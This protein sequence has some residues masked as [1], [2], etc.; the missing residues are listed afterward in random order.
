MV[1][2]ADLVGGLEFYTNHEYLNKRHLRNRVW[3]VKWMVEAFQCSSSNL[4]TCPR[5][6][7]SPCKL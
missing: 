6:L 1:Y 5:R 2:L 3:R 7:M 4:P